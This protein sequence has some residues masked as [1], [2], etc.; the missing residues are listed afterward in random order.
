MQTSN[1]LINMHQINRW[2]RFAERQA[3]VVYKFSDQLQ[4]PGAGGGLVRGLGKG[5]LKEE[6]DYLTDG[7]GP[8]N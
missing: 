1:R 2:R 7:R 5:L 8:S 6:T 3:L 4:M